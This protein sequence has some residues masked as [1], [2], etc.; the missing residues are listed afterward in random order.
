MI[1]ITLTS[2][3]IR[4]APREVRQWIEHEVIAALGLGASAVAPSQNAA[5]I[6]SL[7]VEEAA[8]V[9]TQ[10]RA[11]CLRS[12]CSSNSVDLPVPSASRR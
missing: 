5:R 2:E 8:A 3:Q 7:S 4:S 11:W 9:M 12:T 6:V 1:G 10:I